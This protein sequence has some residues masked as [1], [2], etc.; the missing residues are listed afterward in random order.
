M[1]EQ[2]TERLCARLVR[3]ARAL[4]VAYRS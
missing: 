2:E 4:V 3:H 1:G